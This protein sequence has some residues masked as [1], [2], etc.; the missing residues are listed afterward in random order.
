MHPGRDD[1]FAPL[2]EPDRTPVGESGFRFRCHPGVPC[3]TD[4]CRRLTLFLYPYDVLRLRRALGMHSADFMHRYTRIGPGSHPYFPGVL[5]DMREDEER[6]CPFLGPQGCQVY[7]DRPSSCRYYPLER[8]VERLAAGKGLRAHYFLTHHPYCRGHEETHR[9]T[10][11]EWE[12]DQDLLEYNTMNDLWA[13]VDA[14]FATNPWRG[15]GKAGPL[16]QLAFMVCFNIDGFRSY[17]QQHRLLA[18]SGLDRKTRRKIERGDDTELLKFGF[19]WIRR[20]L[21]RGRS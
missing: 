18:A 6:T 8:G 9:Y 14:F 4:C 5:L 7:R 11:R 19:A 12:L 15:E 16:Q 17:A 20:V 2:I 13:E 1:P 21:D 10:I 3:Y